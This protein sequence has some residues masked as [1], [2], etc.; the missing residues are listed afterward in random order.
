MPTDEEIAK[1]R[2]QLQ[3]ELE[4]ENEP[5]L[6]KDKRL[7][8]ARQIEAERRN[9]LLPL[10]KDEVG[11]DMTEEEF[12]RYCKD[13]NEFPRNRKEELVYEKGFNFWAWI[14]E[15]IKKNG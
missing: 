11:R 6:M 10:F 7:E 13:F 3:R 1:K 4:Q 8:K 2:E 9:I 14:K 12:L 15:N 5:N